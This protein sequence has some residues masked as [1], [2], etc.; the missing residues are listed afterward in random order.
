M[1][2]FLPYD[3]FNMCATVLD[4]R[5]LGKQRVECKQILNALENGGGW[6]NHPAVKMWAGYEDALK[7][8][9]NL[10]IAE[11]VLRGY[12]NNMPYWETSDNI[13]LPVWLGMPS[14]HESHRANLVRK[15]PKYYRD[16][17]PDI[18][19]QEGYYWPV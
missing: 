5:R 14:L 7:L 15:D 2:T 19:P 6:R 10:M 18:E 8:Y 11:W 1:H 4:Y 3:D 17:W 12:N 13:V 16:F 9:G